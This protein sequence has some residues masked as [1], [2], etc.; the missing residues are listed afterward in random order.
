MSGAKQ[1]ILQYKGLLIFLAKALILYFIWQILWYS[2]LN[3][4]NN[5]V[6]I[7]LNESLKSSTLM[8]LQSLGF[9]TFNNNAENHL[10]ITD[11]PGFIIGV[12]CNGL[13]L[14]YL[15]IAFF[16]A[17]PGK[18]KSKLF[19]SIIGIFI[20][21]T[22]NVLRLVLLA[23]ISKYH[24]DWFNFHHSYTF[25]LLMYAIIFLLWY[26]YLKKYAFKKT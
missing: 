21:Y 19:F 14:F 5:T 16:I 25:T 11:S 4:P 2:Y 20:I 6:N 13:D 12:P 22:F 24:Y 8:A 10:G 7:S 17:V 1:N 15:Y 26:F 3:N 23:L 9:D 18:W